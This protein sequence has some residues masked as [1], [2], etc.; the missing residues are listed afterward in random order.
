MVER[1]VDLVDLLY[2]KNREKCLDI[3]GEDVLQQLDNFVGNIEE[4]QGEEIDVD[5]LIDTMFMWNS[6]LVTKAFDW[7]IPFIKLRS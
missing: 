2:Y 5:K 6:G 7:V 1:N 3:F 4:P